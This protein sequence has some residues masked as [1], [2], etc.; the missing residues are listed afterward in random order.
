MSRAVGT[1]QFAAA[2]VRVVVTEIFAGQL[3]KLGACVSVKHGF[4]GTG[5][6][7]TI[8]FESVK[9]KPPILPFPKENCPDAPKSVAF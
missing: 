5:Q 9:P 8:G 2:E 7:A 1:V 4:T 6:V 3:L